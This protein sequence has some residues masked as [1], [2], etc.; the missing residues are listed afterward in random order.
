MEDV[1]ATRER[2]RR[3]VIES[4]KAYVNSLKGLYSAFLIGSYARGDF[5]AWS[6]VDVLLVGDFHG[7]PLERLLKLDFPPGFEVIPL[8]EEEFDRA[9][10][11]N[12][13]II[14]DVKSY[15]IVLRDD[16]NLC[17][18]YGLKCV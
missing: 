7:N 17:K 15:G 4:A 3:R 2:E 12:N 5:N 1:I 11:K 18:K 10:K 13:P 16:L 8:T 14:Y 6:D 9:L